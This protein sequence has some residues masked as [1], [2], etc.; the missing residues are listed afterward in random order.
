[1]YADE[2]SLGVWNCLQ[3]DHVSSFRIANKSSEW[4]FLYLLAWIVGANDED[5]VVIHLYRVVPIFILLWD[6]VCSLRKVIDLPSKQRGKSKVVIA[7]TFCCGGEIWRSGRCLDCHTINHRRPT[8]N[9]QA[10]K[11]HWNRAIHPKKPQ[12]WIAIH[13][14]RYFQVFKHIV[15][16]EKGFQSDCEKCSIVVGKG[17]G[18][19]SIVTKKSQSRF[20]GGSKSRHHGCLMV[21]SE[22][23]KH[24]EGFHLKAYNQPSVMW[25]MDYGFTDSRS[26]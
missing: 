25:I 18:Q 15:P 9:M 11:G 21:L 22:S 20:H 10:G 4:S 2:T 6:V 17:K 16:F 19:R 8:S 1:M 13:H 7:M 26:S 12:E 5:W 14:D 23:H 24:G 3:R